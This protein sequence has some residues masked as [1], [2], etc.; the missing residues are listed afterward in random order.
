LANI[1]HPLSKQECL[2]LANELMIGAKYENNL[3][4]KGTL[5]EMVRELCWVQQIKMKYT[6]NQVNTG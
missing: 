6:D 1:G 4:K 5:M 3:K 2:A